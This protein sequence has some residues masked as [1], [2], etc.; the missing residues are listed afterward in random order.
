MPPN[1]Y[2]M[3]NRINFV[4]YGKV[5]STLGSICLQVQNLE[6]CDFYNFQGLI[7]AEQK[8]FLEYF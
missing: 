7:L 1:I 4:K 6:F 3:V 2:E 8:Y 5:C